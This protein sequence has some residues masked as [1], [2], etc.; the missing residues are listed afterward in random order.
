MILTLEEVEHIA[1]LARLRLDNSEKELYQI[2]LS[3]ILDFAARLQSVETDSIPPTSSVIPTHSVL[4]ND[5]SRPGI[6][7][8]TLFKNTFKTVGRQYQVPP[9]LE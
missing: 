7:L 4:R 9:V 1:D 6:S 5:E 2:Q 3:S 8:N